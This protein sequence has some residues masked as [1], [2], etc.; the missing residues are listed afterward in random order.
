[1]SEQDLE[2]SQDDLRYD[3]DQD[4]EE[5]RKIRE[6]YRTELRNLEGGRAR[7]SSQTRALNATTL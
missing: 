3:P 2:G 5:K 7:P 1:M 4:P 6:G